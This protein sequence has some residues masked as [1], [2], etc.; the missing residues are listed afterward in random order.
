[1]DKKEIVIVNHIV[2]DIII[3]KK[4]NKN[5]IIKELEVAVPKYNLHSICGKI[6]WIN[7]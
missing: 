5:N 3:D 1:M 6:G 2:Q 7:K 4:G